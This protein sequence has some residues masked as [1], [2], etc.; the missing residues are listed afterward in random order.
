MY[1]PRN[2]AL[3]F[4]ISVGIKYCWT[5]YL[6]PFKYCEKDELLVKI[7][8]DKVNQ[9]ST[10]F[11]L[12]IK[13]REDDGLVEVALVLGQ[14]SGHFEDGRRARAIVIDTT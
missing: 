10:Y 5:K 2:C 9:Y 11:F 13:E 14:Q 6:L 8:L 7:I 1:A 12:E 3:F 4:R